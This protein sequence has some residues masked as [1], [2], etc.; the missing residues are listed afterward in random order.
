MPYGEDD[1]DMVYDVM[2]VNSSVTSAFVDSTMLTLKRSFYKD[3]HPMLAKELDKYAYI[4]PR[5]YSTDL[6]STGGPFID[7]GVLR[8]GDEVSIFQTCTND[9]SD[10]IEIETSAINFCSE[11]TSIM[12]HSRPLVPGLPR[13]LT[14]SFTVGPGKKNVLACLDMVGEAYRDKGG[15]FL[16]IPVFYRVDPLMSSSS[17][18]STTTKSLPALLAKHVHTDDDEDFFETRYL[19]G[20]YD[21]KQQEQWEDSKEELA[22]RATADLSQTFNQ[23]KIDG[24]WDVKAAKK[25]VKN[26]IKL[27]ATLN[28]NRRPVSDGPSSPVSP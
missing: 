27:H 2:S 14:V 24:C 3:Y 6:L 11:D 13:T 17:I 7:L 25:K 15:V 23:R 16:Q 21:E 19:T 9:T 22:M 18:P 8:P 4:T 10:L 5:V 26:N 28:Y 12:S 1:E 20:V